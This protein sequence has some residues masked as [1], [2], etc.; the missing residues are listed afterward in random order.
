MNMFGHVR[1]VPKGKPEQLIKNRS[2]AQTMFSPDSGMVNG[3]AGVV[4]WATHT[5]V[6]GGNGEG[7]VYTY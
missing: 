5:I 3:R 7:V 6:G 1:L 2:S 4:G